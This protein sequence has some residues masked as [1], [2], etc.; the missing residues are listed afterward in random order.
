MR[1]L[2]G[3]DNLAQH[4]TCELG[5]EALDEIE[6][7]AVL[8]R[9]HEG[10]ATVALLGEPSLRL[11]GDVGGMIVE[12]DLD[13]GR[14][15]IG[16]VELF[17]K[18]HELARAMPFLDTAMNRTGQKIDA[19]QK[20]QRPV[21]HIFVVARETPV[22]SRRGRQ[23]RT[24]RLASLHD[25]SNERVYESVIVITDRVVLDKQLQDTI[26]QFEHKHGVVQ[27]IDESSDAVAPIACMSGF[28]S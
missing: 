15:R 12:D 19:G 4:G 26:Y 25:A 13:R 18:A 24:H 6:P 27:K 16:G 11:P 5:E 9:E 8:G 23:V 28:S 10:E 3:L 22:P 20:A 7:G 14:L 1:L 2:Q 21:S 17:E